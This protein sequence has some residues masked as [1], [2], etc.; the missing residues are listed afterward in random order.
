VRLEVFHCGQV[1]VV[2]TLEKFV[3][4]TAPGGKADFLFKL[5]VLIVICGILNHLRHLLVYGF[6]GH[7]TYWQ[8]LFDASFTALP[9]GAF[10]LMLIGH[11]SALQKLL[12]LQATRDPLTDLPNRRWF[13]EK[14]PETLAPSQAVMI[15]DID[16]FKLINDTLGHH[17]GDACLQQMAKHLEH[18]IETGDILARI[19]GEEFAAVIAQADDAK[20]HRIATRMAEGILLHAGQGAAKTVSVSVGIARSTVMLSRLEAMSLADKAVYLAKSEGRARYRTCIK[21]K[22]SEMREPQAVSIPA[23]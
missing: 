15:I 21:E 4:L 6:P 12:Y 9:M 18:C 8:N 11:L 2:Q 16:H 14:A 3:R 10:G 19:G 23:A 17:I 1:T 22:A 5:T 7:K 20:L 13:M